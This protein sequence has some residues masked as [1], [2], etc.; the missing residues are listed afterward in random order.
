MYD[1][2]L[3]LPYDPAVTAVA[4]ADDLL[5]IVEGDGEADVREKAERTI[6]EAARWMKSRGLDVA[7]HKTEVAVIKGPRSAEDFA[8]T[9]EGVKTVAKPTL[10]YL[11]VILGKNLNFS[12]HVK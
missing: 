4:Y 1:G 7:H 9:V 10:K 11:G 2:V 3:R 8:I 6:R 5:F 12:N